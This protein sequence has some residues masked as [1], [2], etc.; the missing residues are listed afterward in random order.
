MAIERIDVKPYLSSAVVHGD[1]VY[2]AGIVA[3]AGETVAEQTE[4]ILAQIDDL[5]ARAGTDKSRLLTANIWLTDI[6]T[7]DELNEVWNAWLA[8]GSAP[9]RAAV[10]AKLAS[11]AY[12][13]EIMVTAALV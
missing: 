10:E 11:P 2:L 7:R 6:A 4:N 12:K 3:T 5:L 8:P 9:A 13:V 1:V